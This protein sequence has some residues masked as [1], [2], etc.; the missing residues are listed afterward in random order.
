MIIIEAL[1][2]DLFKYSSADKNKRQLEIA[3]HRSII[4]S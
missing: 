2:K 3:S 1:E 4:Y